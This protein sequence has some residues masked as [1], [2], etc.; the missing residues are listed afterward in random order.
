[1]PKHVCILLLIRDS[2]HLQHTHDE[3]SEFVINFADFYLQV[4]KIF[5]SWKKVGGFFRL[6]FCFKVKKFSMFY[7]IDFFEE[8]IP[9]FSTMVLKIAKV[10]KLVSRMH[11]Q[12]CYKF[13]SITASNFFFFL[14]F[15]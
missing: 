6:K 4:F 9:F 10:G 1:M 14:L 2:V 15:K 3:L 11:D 13:F 12:L 8:N 7:F 5:K